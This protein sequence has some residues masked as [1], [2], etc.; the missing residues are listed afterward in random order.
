MRG[1]KPIILVCDSMPGKV[2]TVVEAARLAGVGI[3]GIHSAVQ[4]NRPVG[5]SKFVFRRSAIQ[6]SASGK[7]LNEIDAFL[8]H[9]GKWFFAPS[10]DVHFEMTNRL[11]TMLIRA[12]REGADQCSKE[13]EASFRI[14][15]E[16]QRQL[17]VL[18]ERANAILGMP[19]V[20]SGPNFRDLAMEASVLGAE[21]ERRL[22]E[23]NAQPN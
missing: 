15:A 7:K 6:R 5:K 9:F 16:A 18:I 2:F 22:K 23:K 14:N 12:K 19:R 11:A 8:R 3:Y 21:L 1:Q 10:V 4:R 17:L 13:L 20:I